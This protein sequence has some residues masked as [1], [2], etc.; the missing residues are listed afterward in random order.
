MK[1]I[2]VRIIFTI[3]VS[4][5]FLLIA[6]LS[7]CSAMVETLVE[8]ILDEVFIDYPYIEEP[9]DDVWMRSASFRYENEAS[10]YWKS[11]KE[12]DTY[13][14]GDCE[15][16]A[17]WMIY[18]LGGDATLIRFKPSGA[19]DSHVIVR[20]H[21][22][23]IEPHVYGKTYTHDDVYQSP[24]VEEISYDAVMKASTMCFTK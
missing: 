11:P 4:V 21:D 10:E 17:A 9:L 14:R 18:H 1:A 7:S 12:M 23:Y 24:D 2:I 20:Y 13:K 8:P 15:D 22:M 6:L 19:A 16:F 5:A 3:I